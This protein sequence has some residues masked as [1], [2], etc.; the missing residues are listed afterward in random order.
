[1]LALH[2]YRESRCP[3]CSGNLAVTTAAANEGK[4]RA[5]L[6]VQ[7]FRCESIGQSHDAYRDQPQPMSYLHM[8][9]LTPGR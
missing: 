4:F 9:P 5:E 6:P 7:C 2:A 8:V 3:G 1:M